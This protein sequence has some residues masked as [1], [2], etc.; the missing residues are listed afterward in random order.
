M[1][2]KKHNAHGRHRNLQGD[3]SRNSKKEERTQ[4]FK[5]PQTMKEKRNRTILGAKRN[6]KTGHPF[7]T[8]QQVEH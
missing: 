1:R 4:S 5:P 3:T 8:M 2:N 6:F 7:H